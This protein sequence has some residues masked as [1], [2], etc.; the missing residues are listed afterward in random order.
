EL[1]GEREH[2]LPRRFYKDVKVAA[3]T[4]GGHSVLLDGRPVRT[5]ARRKLLLPN[6]AVAQLV[7]DEFSAQQDRID[8]A[9]MP[10]TRIVNSALDGVADGGEAIRHDLLHYAGTDLLC[11]RADGPDGLR[12]AQQAAWD[13]V[14]R[15]ADEAL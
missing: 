13:P 10:V 6:E 9:R 12:Q 1:R 3:D 2:A 8:P 5:P 7:A 15:W 4:E 14:L 11:Y